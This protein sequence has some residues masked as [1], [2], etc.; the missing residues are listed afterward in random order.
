MW[1]GG[2]GGNLG[3]RRG[4]KRVGREKGCWRSIP[5]P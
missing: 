5:A 4:I 3:G 2:A 1:E